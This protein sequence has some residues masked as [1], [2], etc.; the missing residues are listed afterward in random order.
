[1]SQRSE[2]ER[3]TAA[4]LDQSVDTLDSQTLAHIRDLRARAIQRNRHR[5]GMLWAGGLAVAC[6]SALLAVI[7]L[8][9]PASPT[10]LPLDDLSLITSS[11]ELELLENLDFYEWLAADELS[12]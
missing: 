9:G 12:S 11:D 5:R 6:A 3:K 2:F 4:V 10:A 1:M 8:P 7:Y